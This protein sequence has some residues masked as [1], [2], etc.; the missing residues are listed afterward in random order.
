[1]RHE[2]KTTWVEGMQVET[3]LN[4]HA[5]HLD[6]A[7][8]FGGMDKGV[9]SKPLMLL[10]LAGC[11]SMDVLSLLRKMR[12]EITNFTVDVTAELTDEHPKT[13]SSTHIIYHFHGE[14]LDTAKI[15]RAVELSFD[16]YCGV[17]AMFK[18]F[19]TVTKEIRYS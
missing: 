8:E 12:V 18:K 2:I 4:G 13:Y 10:S 9:R 17:I 3:T 6:A 11:T 16:T 5:I 1:M 7:P 14:N 19:S 15:E